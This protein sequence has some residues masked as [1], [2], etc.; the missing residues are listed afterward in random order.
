VSPNSPGTVQWNGTYE[1]MTFDDQSDGTL[2]S[3][4]FDGT[5]GDNVTTVT[6]PGS[7]EVDGSWTFFHCSH[8]GLCRNYIIAPQQN[9]ADVLL[10]T[11]G[12]ESAQ[13]LKTI[14]GV[15]QPFGATLSGRVRKPR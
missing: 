2:Y 8:Q 12:N 13:R 10:Y 3:Y 4:K 7:T 15:T 9:A 14:T 1:Q 5:S 6:L 11:Y